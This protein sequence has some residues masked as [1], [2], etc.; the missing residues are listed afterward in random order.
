LT[1]SDVTTGDSH[2]CG[3]TGTSIF[4]WGDSADGQAG[5]AVSG[6]VVDAPKQ[7][8][9]AWIAVSAGGSHTCAIS[10]TNELRCWGSNSSGQLGAAQPVALPGGADGPWSAVKAGRTHTCAVA[11]THTYCWGAGVEGALG[12]AA[13][14]SSSTPVQVSTSA[15]LSSHQLG[16]D[17]SCGIALDAD[18]GS[19]FQIYCWGT[20]QYGLLL[21]ADTKVNV[22]QL[23]TT[24]GSPAWTAYAVGAHHMCAVAEG[25]LYC[26][27]SNADGAVGHAAPD[28]TPVNAPTLVKAGVTPHSATFCWPNPCRNG[29]DCTELAD[30]YTCD[31]AGTGFGGESCTTEIDECATAGICGQGTC[32]DLLDGHGYTCTCPDGLID[33]DGTGTSCTAVEQISAGAGHSCVLTAAKTLHCWGSNRNGQLGLGTAG[34][35]DYYPNESSQTYRTPLRLKTVSGIAGDVSGWTHIAVGEKHTCA[36]LPTEV[37]SSEGLYCWGD[38]TMGQLGIPVVA[39]QFVAAPVL[40][41]NTQSWIALSASYGHN[42][43]INSAGVLYCWGYNLA[44]QVGNGTAVT[45]QQFTLTPVPLPMGQSS[46]IAVS[47]GGNHTC[48]TTNTNTMYCWGRR[49]SGQVGIGATGADV[50]SPTRVDKLDPQGFGAVQA[51]L[52]TSC[53][54]A[55]SAAYCWGAGTTGAIGNGASVSQPSPTLVA[56]GLSFNSLALGSSFACGMVA[57]MG[58]TPQAYSAY[59]WGSNS[60]NLHLTGVSGAAGNINTPTALTARQWRVFDVGS[61]H[62]CGVDH[63]DGL[64]YC[65]GDNGLEVGIG[66]GKLG[67]VPFSMLGNFGIGVVKTAPAPHPAQ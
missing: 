50:L 51:E 42:C 24:A 2:T 29:G 45:P 1:W 31:C 43:G 7:I 59:C 13:F 33:A 8:S 34:T 25:L 65:W 23:V 10:T 21:T 6:T 38:N 56:G 30:G 41:D 28:P 14:A 66:K 3:L 27:G 36:T 64:L 48:A 15:P 22:P 18:G 53:A 37:G 57:V 11:G 4:C 52:S 17:F 19:A 9:D 62:I 49:S 32:R 26:W 35:T 46:W 20:N 44:G 5:A 40:L 67:T 47:A 63:A 16:E 12:N 39:P 58:T 60:K 61:S 55:G 54:L